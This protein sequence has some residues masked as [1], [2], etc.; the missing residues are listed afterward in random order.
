MHRLGDCFVALAILGTT[1]GCRL[2]PLAPDEPGASENVLPR[3]TPIPAVTSNNALMSQIIVND[4]LDT[5][6]LMTNHNVI[7]RGTGMMTSAV[8]DG[9]TARYWAFG[10][11]DRAPT[12]IYVFGQGDPMSPSFTPLTDHPPLV[13][14]VP[15]D[16]DYEAVHAIFNVR[17]T[18]KYDGQRITTPAALSDAIDLGLV[19][20]PVS[21]KV[22]VN[23]PIVRSGLR[24][25]VAT[26]TSVPPTPVYAHGYQVDSFPLGGMFG[27]QPNP[28]GLLPTAQVS[29]LREAGKPSYDRTR[30]I[31]Q[32]TVPT[33][34]PGATSTYTP[35]SVVVKVD[36]ARGVNATDI[37]K[38]GDLFTRSTTTGEIVIADVNKVAQLVVTDEIIDLQIQ[39]TDG[40]P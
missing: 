12:P 26:G 35:V 30:P 19:E 38:D 15:G 13:E 27:R 24:L 28:F 5:L 32:A 36:L 20:A 4:H 16:V 21:I 9:V 31:F 34:A 37:R 2:G 23:W 1:S 25:E 8:G 33:A 3:D 11:A 10:E 7:V 17:V 6:A 40:A 18:E 14:V 29:F 39:F 22:F